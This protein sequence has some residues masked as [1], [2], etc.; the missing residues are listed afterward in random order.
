MS[1]PFEHLVR[2][3]VMGLTLAVAGC[4]HMIN[5]SPPLNTLE[6]SEIIKSGKTVGYYISAADRARK[7]TTP[8]GGG[9]SVSYT[10]YAD[11]EPAM[12]DVLTR[13]FGVAVAVPDLNDKKF[14]SDKHV[15]YVFVP[16]LSTKSSSSS[17]L[18]W[19]PTHFE[20]TIDCK[21]IDATGAATVWQ[22][23]V[24]GSGEAVFADF[25]H[26]FSLAARRASKAAFV[27]P[28]SR[29]S[30]APELK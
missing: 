8:G 5:I 10:P 19:P 1:T 28:Q 27:E 7:V 20:L 12:Q 13:I 15:A 14:L 18:T 16:T 29:I 24:T 22:T 2:A 25:K 3:T 17:A 4:A 21:A 30:K 6:A 26:D 9:D 11:A 23:S